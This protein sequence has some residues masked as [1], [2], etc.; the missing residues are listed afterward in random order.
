MDLSVSGRDGMA[1]GRRGGGR[2]A[3]ASRGGP[4]V[5]QAARLLNKALA[6][7]KDEL[8]RAELAESLAAVAGRLEPAEAA[9]VCGSGKVAEP[10]LGQGNR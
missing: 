10:G 6:E 2:A 4:H 1:G 3:G 9:A 7:E 5:A 8:V